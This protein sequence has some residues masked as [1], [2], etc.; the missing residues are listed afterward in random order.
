MWRQ[1]EKFT[2]DIGLDQAQMTD[3]FTRAAVD[4]PATSIDLLPTVLRLYADD[5]MLYNL[6][7][8]PAGAYDVAARQSEVA[9]RLLGHI[10]RWERDWVG[11]PRGW[12]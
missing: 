7:L 3:D 2:P 11:N 9:A 8:D 12:K 10:E 1:G 5:P 6:G 4:A